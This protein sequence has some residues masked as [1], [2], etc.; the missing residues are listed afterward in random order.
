VT[1]AVNL[2]R[3]R[4]EHSGRGHGDP[5]L[6]SR[7]SGQL[8]ER[9]PNAL[10]LGV[11]G[12]G[13]EVLVPSGVLQSLPAEQGAQ[14][15]LVIYEYLQI[16]HSRGTPILIGF[17]NELE[18]DFFEQFI[19]VASIGPRMAVRALAAPVSHIAQAIE[20]GDLRV[21]QGLPGIGAR[22]AKE[23]VA[24]LQGK[25]GRFCLIRDEAGAPSREERAENIEREAIDLLTQ[26]GHSRAEAKDMVDRALSGGE[27]PQTVEELLNLSYKKRGL[28]G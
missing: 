18:R 9:K 4:F 20:D 27:R 24:K 21:L 14:L 1:S 11:N 17:R 25:A 6:I 10:I 7:L 16:D 26:V 12:I 15:E 8:L 2:L 28:P 22:K 5:R 23:I 19:T 13:Y 3:G